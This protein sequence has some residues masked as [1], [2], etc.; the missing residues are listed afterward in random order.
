MSKMN[1]YADIDLIHK[2]EIEYFK[3]IMRDDNDLIFVH[4]N[5]QK[6]LPNEQLY[7]LSLEDRLLDKGARLFSLKVDVKESKERDWIYLVCPRF[8]DF[9]DE[10]FLG[11]LENKLVVTEYPELFPESKCV[12]DIREAADYIAGLKDSRDEKNIADDR[13]IW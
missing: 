8:R 3:R 2:P 7:M 13:V 5:L 11:T 12:R 6:N 4:R 10:P 1:V 9:K